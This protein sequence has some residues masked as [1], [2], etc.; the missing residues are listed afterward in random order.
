[1]KGRDFTTLPLAHY[2]TLMRSARIPRP[3]SYQ[4]GAVA[5]V[6][7]R[8]NTGLPLLYRRGYTSTA[9]NLAPAD[10]TDIIVQPSKI[11]NQ[12]KD[13]NLKVSERAASRLSQINKDSHEILKVGIESGGCHG[14]QYTLQL[15]PESKLDL[16][17]GLMK[18]ETSKDA[19]TV[20]KETEEA[21]EFD[22]EANAKLTIYELEDNTGKVAIDPKSLKVLNNTVLTYTKELIGSS[23][24]ISGGSMKSSCGCGSSFDVDVEA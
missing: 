8:G 16:V 12:I 7:R 15:I 24:K 9:T 17:T 2:I 20:A 22:D 1:M 23:F 19:Q 18:E 14:F 5:R 11:I 21:D 6:L 13:L 3:L 10:P 4:T